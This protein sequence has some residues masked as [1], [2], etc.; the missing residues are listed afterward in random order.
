MPEKPADVTFA[1]SRLYEIEARIK[2]LDYS[3]DIVSVTVNSSLS[4]SYQVLDLVFF[5]DSN[6]I[7]LQELY[8]GDPI[9]LRIVLLR[10][11]TGALQGG[12][13]GPSIEFELMYVHHEFPIVEKDQFSQ[14][15][16]K[17]RV[18]YKVTTVTRTPY[19]IMTTLVN[20]VFLGQTL[21]SII[22][23]LAKDA[24][25]TDIEFDSDGRN[26]NPIDQV[27]I[28]PTTFYQVIKEFDRGSAFLFDGYLDGRFGLFNGVPGIF[29]QFDGK[30]QIKNLTAKMKKKEAFMVYQFSQITSKKESDRITDAV[31][32]GNVFYTYD[33][34]DSD[35]SASS[36]FAVLGTNIKD[37]VKPKNT[38]T[39]TITQS[40]Q[41]YTESN[42]LIYQN[43]NLF[44]DPILT[45]DKYNSED[46]GYEINTTQ[47]NSRYGRTMADTASL[48]LQLERDMPLLNLVQVGEAVMF[49][50]LSL[51]YQQLSGKYILWSSVLNFRRLANWE[52]TATI[53]LIRSN[54]HSGQLG[55]RPADTS[56]KKKQKTFAEKEAEQTKKQIKAGKT[57]KDIRKPQNLV[58]RR[59]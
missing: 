4:T 29:C 55:L 54:R 34:I 38:L 2:D 48:S 31:V 15:T 28:P 44:I 30:V 26:S 24:G 12:V 23:Q 56:D 52:A 42:S 39:S 45:R 6:D 59:D 27:I 11:E 9:N 49:K 5:L 16:Q 20:R 13:P 17:D 3:Q 19:K 25:A 21:E 7:I 57:E 10:E 50:P 18:A 35:Y 43:A 33:T 14:Q 51:E 47:F 58:F 53:N 46:T 41:Q 32:D 22:T 36:K 8:G 37:I 40:L 1:P